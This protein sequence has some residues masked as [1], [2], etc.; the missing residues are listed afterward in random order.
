MRLASLRPDELTALF[1]TLRLPAGAQGLLQVS[2]AVRI[3]TLL[4]LGDGGLSGC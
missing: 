3:L 1:P 4:T 2:A